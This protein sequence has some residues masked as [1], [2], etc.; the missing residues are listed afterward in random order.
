MDSGIIIRLQNFK[1]AILMRIARALGFLG[2]CSRRD[3]E[4]LIK[5][6]RVLVNGNVVCSPIY[7]VTHSDQI[8]IDGK[9]ISTKPPLVKIWKFFKPRKVITSTYDQQNR[10]TVFNYL[11]SSI[12]R[13]VTIGRLDYNTEGLL[14]FTNR[15]TIARRFELPKSGYKRKYLCQSY[16]KIP[17]TMAQELLVGLNIE[18]IQYRKIKIKTYKSKNL[19]NWTEITLV[20]GKNREIRKIFSYYSL[21]VI[22]LIRTEY[23]PYKLGKM[24]PRELQAVSKLVI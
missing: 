15:G 17:Q 4:S 19:I 10:S 18:G 22:K 24:K 7:F 1:F 9:M 6:R 23:G 13:V 14:L 11:P 21:K 16:G 3:G 5:Q 20:E 8:V 2:V 12:G